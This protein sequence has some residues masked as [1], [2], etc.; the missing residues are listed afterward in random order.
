VGT[1]SAEG[2]AAV[3]GDCAGVGAV[4]AAGSARAAAAGL[5]LTS[6]LRVR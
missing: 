4:V 5:E 1:A 2:V 6:P 3:A